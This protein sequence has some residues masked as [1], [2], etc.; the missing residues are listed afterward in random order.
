LVSVLDR[1]HIVTAWDMLVLAI[2]A[3]EEIAIEPAVVAEVLVDR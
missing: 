1:E 3:V 2:A